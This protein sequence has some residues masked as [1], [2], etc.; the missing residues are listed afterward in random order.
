MMMTC[1]WQELTEASNARMLKEKVTQ[2]MPFLSTLT[3]ISQYVKLLTEV[4]ASK[5]QVFLLKFVSI[6]I[7]LNRNPK[8]DLVAAILNITQQPGHGLMTS[9]CRRDFVH[10]FFWGSRVGAVVRALAFHQCVGGSIPGPG[11]IC[12]LSLL[13]LYSAPRGFSPGTPVFPSP[14]KP[15]FDLFDVQSP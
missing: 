10:G 6:E 5:V 8:F 9:F 14:Q 3:E 7:R 13:V 11:I 15:T 12:G 2:K 1:A 4:S